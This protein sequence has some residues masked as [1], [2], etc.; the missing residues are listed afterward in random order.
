MPTSIT[1]EEVQSLISEKAG[2]LVEVLP[3]EEYQ[4]EHIEGALNIP[5]KRLNRET[6]SHID[7]SRPVIVY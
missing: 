7:R 4:D 6:A 5:L 3:T 2:Q 1:R